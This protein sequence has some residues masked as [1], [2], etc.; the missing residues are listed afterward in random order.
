MGVWK[1]VERQYD[2]LL[3]QN[4]IRIVKIDFNQF[5]MTNYLKIPLP[6][7]HTPILPHLLS[8]DP[9]QFCA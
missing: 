2:S 6:H 5:D 8:L 4:K 3:E 7:S 9:D 1:C